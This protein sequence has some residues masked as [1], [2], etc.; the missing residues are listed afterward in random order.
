ML[1]ET[2]SSHVSLPQVEGRVPSRSEG[3]ILL[4]P[5]GNFI[6]PESFDIT[7]VEP[8]SSSME[9]FAYAPADGDGRAN[10]A[11]TI[12]DKDGRI[13]ERQLFGGAITCLVP[14]N[15]EDVSVIRQ[16]PDHQEVL[17]DKE[18]EMSLIIELLQYDESVSNDCAARHYFDDLAHFNEV[19]SQLFTSLGL[20]LSLSLLRRQ[21]T[22]LFWVRTLSWMKASCLK[23][24]G[25]MPNA[26]SWGSKA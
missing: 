4:S 12:S 14:T 17:V 23:C 1:S 2:R 26:L 22:W 3:P 15:F 25:R 13:S 11:S 24:D 5:G 20:V 21:I 8:G 7:G 10:P 16:V 18:S 6:V 19:G 9:Y